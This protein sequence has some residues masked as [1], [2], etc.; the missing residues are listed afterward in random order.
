MSNFDYGYCKRSR[1]FQSNCFQSNKQ[2]RSSKPKDKERVLE[3]IKENKFSPSAT[4]RNLSKGTSSAI[5]FVV[6]R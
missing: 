4:A 1:G 5:G 3:I 2:F 6:P